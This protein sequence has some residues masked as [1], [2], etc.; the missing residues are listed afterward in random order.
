MIN[1]IL[2]IVIL[3]IILFIINNIFYK[4]IEKF[5]NLTFPEYNPNISNPFGN[6]EE[7]NNYGYGK[8]WYQPARADGLQYYKLDTPTVDPKLVILPKQLTDTNRKYNLGLFDYNDKFCN[9]I[10]SKDYEDYIDKNN[11]KEY[12]SIN[13]IENN[14][15]ENLNIILEGETLNKNQKTY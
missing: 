6:G 15:L 2:I 13:I 10:N 9:S 12:N 4:K 8:K 3:I 1:I 11:I 7:V 14:N 5:Q